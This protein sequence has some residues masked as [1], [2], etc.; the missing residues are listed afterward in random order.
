MNHIDIE[1]TNAKCHVCAMGLSLVDTL[2]H[3]NRCSFCAHSHGQQP[4]TIGIL[5][6][7]LVAFYD[8]K[9][10]RRLVSLINKGED[11]TALIGALG[12]IGY[13]DIT[14][15]KT[16]HR[17]RLLFKALGEICR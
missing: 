4:K 16:V 2:I 17:K 3:G 7:L 5:Y 15:V 9:I 8:W 13:Q 10:H 11:H 6:F 12:S 1:E 14:A